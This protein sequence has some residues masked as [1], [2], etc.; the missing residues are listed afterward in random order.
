MSF[1]RRKRPFQLPPP[2]GRL[3]ARCRSYQIKKPMFRKPFFSGVEI[4]SY[5]S[6]AVIRYSRLQSLIFMRMQ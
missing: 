1:L 5:A 3:R 6:L 2:S 4:V